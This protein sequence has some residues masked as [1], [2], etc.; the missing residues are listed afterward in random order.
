M[1]LTGPWVLGSGFTG[2]TGLGFIRLMGFTGR[3]GSSVQGSQGLRFKVLRVH[4][5]YRVRG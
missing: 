5:V 2:F 3:L 4:A 1:G